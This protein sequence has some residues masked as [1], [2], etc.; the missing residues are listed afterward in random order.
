MIVA[1]EKHGPDAKCTKCLNGPHGLG[2]RCVGNLHHAEQ[3]AAAGD[4]DFGYTAD[5][6]CRRESGD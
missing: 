6:V 1:G 2:S 3:H 5:V 4:I